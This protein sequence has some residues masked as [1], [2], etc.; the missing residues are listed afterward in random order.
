MD[1][2]FFSSEAAA[3]FRFLLISQSVHQIL[4]SCQCTSKKDSRPTTAFAGVYHDASAVGILPT[5]V[6]SQ[7]RLDTCTSNDRGKLKAVFQYT[8]SERPL[9]RHYRTSSVSLTAAVW[10]WKQRQSPTSTPVKLLLSGAKMTLEN[11]LPAIIV[12]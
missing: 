6:A 10:H 8:Y 4:A 12:L 1:S 11:T 3:C 7:H 5:S 9:S 2:M